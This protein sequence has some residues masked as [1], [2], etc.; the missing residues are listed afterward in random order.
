[1]GQPREI[2]DPAPPEEQNARIRRSLGLADN[3]RV[4]LRDFDQGIVETL[5]AFIEDQRYWLSIDGVDPPPGKPG[6]LITFSFP[7]AEFKSYV[8]PLI[9]VRRDGLAPAMERWHPKLETFRAPSPS[10]SR[11]VLPENGSVYSGK[12][13][14]DKMTFGQQAVPYDITYTLTIL[15]HYRGAPGQRGQVQKILQHVL[16]TYPPYSSLT[17]IDSIGDPRAYHTFT[18]SISPQDDHPEVSERTIGFG[19]T[20]RVEAELDFYDPQEART[21]TKPPS[22][23]LRLKQL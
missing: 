10:A 5:G 1:M 22:L 20:V 11:V 23:T 19:V 4:Y 18:E 16:K 15:A 2:L 6:I 14:Y 8:V 13:G 17:L 7:E 3:G 9:L 12:V 21:V